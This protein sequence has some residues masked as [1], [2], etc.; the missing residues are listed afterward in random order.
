MVVKVCQRVPSYCQY[1]TF[2]VH[3]LLLSSVLTLTP[4]PLGLSV[5]VRLIQFNGRNSQQSTAMIIIIIAV[6][7]RQNSS[8]MPMRYIHDPLRW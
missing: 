3:P 5:C 6:I 7:I 8:A 4:L 2:A 1:Y